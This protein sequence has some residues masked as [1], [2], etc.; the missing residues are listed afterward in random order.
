MPARLKYLETVDFS[1]EPSYK[2]AYWQRGEKENPPIY[3]V[4]GLTRNGRDFDYLA[5]ALAE[6]Y[7]VIC[8]D[9]PGRG[10]SDWL[11]D[12]EKY[13]YDTYTSCL[14][15]LMENVENPKAKW[16]GTSLGG[17]LGMRIAAEYPERI[18][19]LVLNDVGAVLP[20]AGLKRISDYVGLSM[21]FS[22]RDSAERNLREIYSEFGIT[23]DKHWNHMLES[24]FNKLSNGEY[25]LA[26]DPGI[27]DSVRNKSK[28][29][30]IEEDVPLWDW[31]D[32][33]SCPILV[34]RGET[35]DILTEAT[36]Q[37]MLERNRHAE[38]VTLPNIGHA[39]S[40]MDEQQI[41][42]IKAWLL[43][44]TNSAKPEQH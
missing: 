19:K 27:L 30:T 41:A 31:W 25:Q 9:L 8:P 34:L 44:N 15:K 6:E 35:S 23:E 18:E 26:Y 17:I 12:T 43:D 22:D 4:H 16:V 24:S 21:Q 36:A 10:K 11:A 38:L 2:L 29:L 7:C 1:F 32:N 3:C 5:R 13:N 28:Q 40:L 20:V 14:I 33:I 42:L 39:P 37:E